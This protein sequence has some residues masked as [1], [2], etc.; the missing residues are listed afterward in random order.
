MA[1]N[2]SILEMIYYDDLQGSI[3]RDIL[4]WSAK[5]FLRSIKERGLLFAINDSQES[6][7]D[8]LLQDFKKI[9]PKSL[10]KYAHEFQDVLYDLSFFKLTELGNWLMENHR[11]FKEE[12]SSSKIPKSYRVHSKRT[13][14]KS[15]LD[16]LIETDLIIN[17]GSVK[18]MKNRSDTTLYRFSSP[19][20]IAGLTSLIVNE[21]EDLVLKYR[22]SSLL[23]IIWSFTVLKQKRTLYKVLIHLLWD[24]APK[25]S[26]LFYEN[27]TPF[28]LNSLFNNK[29]GSLIEVFLFL[30]AYDK[31]IFSSFINILRYYDKEFLKIILLEIKEYVE[32]SYASNCPYINGDWEI[33]RARNAGNY[34]QITIMC[35]CSKCEKIYPLSIDFYEFLKL[36]KLRNDK[37]IEYQKLDCSECRSQMSLNVLGFHS[38]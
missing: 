4:N 5:K 31:S 35:A 28:F 1:V 26:M 16:K 38:Y 2:V 21:K 9:P 20:I 32:F 7:S 24:L 36:P 25:K 29:Y 6:K 14:I 18:S 12:Y 13:Y 22:A 10:P 11:P 17:A 15:K 37:K 30:C 23:F 27:F 33:L 19:G 3:Y 34:S 8:P